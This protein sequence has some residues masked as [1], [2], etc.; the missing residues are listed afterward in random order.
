MKGPTSRYPKLSAP[1][2]ALSHL[3]FR[4]IPHPTPKHPAKKI[5]SLN[6]CNLLNTVY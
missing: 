1:C 3:P 6:T 5:L 2:I 4:I